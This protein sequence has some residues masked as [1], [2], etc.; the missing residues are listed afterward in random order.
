MSFDGQLLARGFWLYVWK[1][2]G[3]RSHCLY[4]GRT[5]DTSSPSASSPFRRIGQH[6][7]LRP[8]A[9]GSTLAKRLKEAG[10]DCHE[11]TFEMTAIGPVFPEQ[12]SFEDHKPSRDLMA[13]LERAL[14]DGLKGR[15]YCVLGIHPSKGSPD[16]LLLSQIRVMVHAK[17][18]AL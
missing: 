16:E 5:G 3:P 6:L 4:V 18:P 9:K 7:D 14:A 13:A 1:I 11:C 10:F 15:G 8:T 12:K 2:R 17:S